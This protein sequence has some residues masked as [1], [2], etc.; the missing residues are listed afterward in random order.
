[1]RS[2]RTAAFS[3]AGDLGVC[4][5]YGVLGLNTWGNGIRRTTVIV[6]ADGGIKKLFDN[7]SPAGHAAE[8]LA[9][10]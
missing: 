5:A 9:A 1:M 6:G 10:L 4:D 2:T 7:V 8:V 3:A